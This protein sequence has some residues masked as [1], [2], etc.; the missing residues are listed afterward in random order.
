MKKKMKHSIFRSNMNSKLKKRFTEDQSQN[1]HSAQ[2]WSEWH[3][4]VSARSDTDDCSADVVKRW[5]EE[6]M[7][8]SENWVCEMKQLKAT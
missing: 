5:H 2:K 8:Q 6:S 4:D 7:W 3:W 1:L